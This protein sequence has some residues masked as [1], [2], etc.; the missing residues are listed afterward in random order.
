MSGKDLPE[1]T[2]ALETAPWDE[3]NIN[4]LSREPVVKN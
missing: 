4:D 2:R 1:I 3:V